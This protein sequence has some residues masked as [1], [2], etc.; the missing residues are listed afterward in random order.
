MWPQEKAKKLTGGSAN[1]PSGWRHFILQQGFSPGF[2]VTHQGA[3]FDL[4]STQILNT[5]ALEMGILYL[6]FWCGSD[7]EWFTG[8][9]KCIL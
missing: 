8:Y 6:L 2:L 3:L 5:T 9:Y 1:T 4:D 7:D